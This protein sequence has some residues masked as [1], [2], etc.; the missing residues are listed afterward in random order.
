MHNYC[1]KPTSHLKCKYSQR[2]G[3]IFIFY[4]GDSILLL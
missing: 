2:L 3:Y 4:Q 1:T